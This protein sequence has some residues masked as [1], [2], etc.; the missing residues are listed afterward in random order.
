[1][2]DGIETGYEGKFDFRGA[3]APP[4]ITYM[5]A[6]VP[7]TG[8]T[9]LSHALWRTGCLGAPLE[10][11]NFQGGPYAFAKNSA[12]LQSSLWRSVLRRRTSPN[13]VFGFKA[14]PTQLQ[15]LR[16]NNPS[17]LAQV[18]SIVD[19]N[20][21]LYLGRRDRTAHIVS[22]ARASLSGIW[23]KEQ[24]PEAAETLDYSQEALEAAERGIDFQAA[25]WERMFRDLGIAPLRLWYEDA[26]ADP[27][28]IA[29]RVADHLG[30]ALD[31]A[32]QVQVPE[33]H[34]QREG[35]ARLWAAKYREA[36]GAS[37][38]ALSSG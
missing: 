2:L 3:Q 33:V 1:M 9:Y 22:Y 26:V 11:L 17:L 14:F 37:P 15:A 31:P 18:M 30:V 23:R 12:D 20:R 36:K 38:S 6:S 27:Q 25:T 34:K 19:P 28:D 7:R 5:L 16:E 35:E 10:Y 29:R 8:S 4:E 24:E 32:A 21:V 13:R